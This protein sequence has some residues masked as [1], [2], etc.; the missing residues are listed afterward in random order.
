MEG[1]LAV[2]C[3]C[4][5]VVGGVR[6]QTTT[7]VLGKRRMRRDELERELAFALNIASAGRDCGGFLIDPADPTSPATIVQAGG[8]M[9]A[10][11][12][13]G[14][15]SAVDPSGQ[16]VTQIP[17]GIIRA[18]CDQLPSPARSEIARPSPGGRRVKLGLDAGRSRT[19]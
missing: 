7:W 13:C 16:K 8:S 18:R 10:A 17:F 1:L 6:G 9:E 5:G 12:V 3:R 19:S 14:W 4:G 11:G 15:A 2:L